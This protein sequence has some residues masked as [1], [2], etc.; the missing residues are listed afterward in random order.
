M[1]ATIHLF[2]LHFLIFYGRLVVKL[3]ACLEARRELVYRLIMAASLEY[4][5]SLAVCEGNRGMSRLPNG[6]KIRQPSLSTL[7]RMRK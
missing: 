4:E 5:K 1:S 6:V 2:E 3:Y 7:V